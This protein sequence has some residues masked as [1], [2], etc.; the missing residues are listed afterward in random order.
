MI[1]RDPHR[2]VN[3]LEAVAVEQLAS[4]LECRARDET[5][6]RLRDNYLARLGLVKASTVLEV[7][8]GTGSVLRALMRRPEFTGSALGIDQSS[9]FVQAARMLAMIDHA[10]GR[11]QFAVGDAHCVDYPSASFDIVIAHTLMS[12]VTSPLSVLREMTRVTRPG[13]SVVVF[14]G[15]Y[16]SLTYAYPDHG[17]GHRI[18]SALATA[19]FNNPRIVRDLPRVMP[20]LGLTLVDAWGEAIVEIGAASYFKSFAETYI[21]HLKAAGVIPTQSIE[22]WYEEQQSMMQKG[23]FFASCN[24]YTYL[25]RRD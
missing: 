22:A 19:T 7:G 18:D 10:A 24:Y 9:H 5:F 23:T 8:C 6:A 16:A 25:A 14:D 12:H 1:A 21:P 2:F 17:F 13:G 15:D 11:L 3:E 4:R 20:K